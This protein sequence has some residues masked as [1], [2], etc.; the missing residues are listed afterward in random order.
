MPFTSHLPRHRTLTAALGSALLALG[1]ATA[2]APARADP[3]ARDA[4]DAPAQIQRTQDL[5]HLKAG[6]SIRA[7]SPAGATW[8]TPADT[9]RA[10]AQERAYSSYGRPT[11]VPPAAHTLAGDVRDGVAAAVRALDPGCADRRH[12]R[13]VGTAPLATP[14]ASSRACS[15][16][17]MCQSRCARRPPPSWRMSWASGS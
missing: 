7:S 3:W 9:Q 14:P 2:T 13:R 4:A 11:P 10:L 5:R 15:L 1:L 8:P 17:P 16:S 12:R 6:N